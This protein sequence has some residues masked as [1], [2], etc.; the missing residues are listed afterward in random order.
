MLFFLGL[1]ALGFNARAERINI[2]GLAIPKLII[3]EVRVSGASSLYVEL[4][5]M[6]DTAINLEPFKLHQ[7][8]YNTRC[9]EYSDSAISFNR[10]NEAVNSQIGKIYLKGVLQPGESILI[11]NVYDANNERGTGIPIHNTAIAQKGDQFAHI[12]ESLNEN[13][14]IDKPEWQCFGRDSVSSGLHEFLRGGET[15]GYLI[16]WT[17]ETDSAT[18]DS[19]YIDN[20]NH[21]WYPE[22]QAAI[23]AN[24]SSKGE[25]IFPIAGVV[26]AIT[27]SVLVR[28]ANVTEGNL[29]WDQS[30][31]TDANTSE[32][33]VIPQNAS[34]DLAFT[35]VG[36]HGVYDLDYSVKDPS[37]IIINGGN[38]S[39]PWQMAREDSLS[40][41]FNLGDGMSWG[42]D[43]VGSF[44]DSAS[45][46]ARTGDMFSLYAVGNE[47]NK[48]EFTLQVREAEADVALVFP[49][50]QLVE[51]IEIIDDGS[52]SATAVDTIITIG[53]S[54]GFVYDVVQGPET[55]SII[56]VPFATR[57][58][59]LFKYLVKPEK[60][61]WEFIFVDGN[62]RVDLQFGDKLKVT[63]ED[64][65]TVKEYFV[66]VSD[67]VPGE[68]ALLSTV[69]WPDVDKTLYPRWN[70]GDTLPEF[71][72]LKT[73]Y[74]VELHFE[75]TQIPA[76]QFITEDLKSRI[77]VNNAVNVDGSLE[78]R[79]TSVTVY[80]E[81]DTTVLT[82]N[83]I[84]QKQGVPVQP[85]VLE[86]FISE[87]VHGV[88]TQGWAVEIY[89]PGTEDLNLS[90]YAFVSGSQSQTWQE[91]VETLVGTG[92]AFSVGAGN[93]SYNTHYFPSK[94]WTADYSLEAW[95]ALP[96]EENP[97]LGKGFL[98]DDNQTDPWV[99]GGDVWIMGI[100]MNTND[101]QTK[102]REESDFLFRGTGES[103]P[104]WDS[105]VL[106]HRETVIWDA[107]RH[108][109]WLLKV[110]NDS[111]LDGTKDVRDASAYELIDRWEIIGDSVAGRDGITGNNW[112]FVRKSTVVKG[113]LE[114][115][116][117][118][119]ETA[120]SSE[121]IVHRGTDLDWTNEDHVANLGIHTINPITNYLST[122]TS[123]FFLVTPGYTGDNL[124][125]TGSITDYTPTTIS[126]LL[127]K[128]DASQTF[129]YMRGETELTA[130]QSLADGDVLVVSAGDGKSITNYTLVNSPLDGNTSLMAKAGSGLTV[131]DDK[132][133]G[134]TVGMT[135]KEALENLEVAEKSVLNVL[136]ATGALQPLNVYTLDSM[137]NDVLVSEKFSLQVVAENNDNATYY[138]D[139]GLAS[140]EAV[141]LSN[142]LQI[143]QDKKWIMDLP[144]GS[145]ASSILSMVFANEGATYRIL[146]KAGFERTM[147]FIYIDDVI[148]VTA[149]DGVTKV[150]YTFSED[151]TISVHPKAESPTNVVI[152]PNP[153]K[154][155][156]NIKGFELAS[157][158]VI[159]ISGTKMI[160]QTASYS[161]RIDVSSLPS[162][163][164]VIRMTDEEGRIAIDKFLKK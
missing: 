35:T 40:R 59:S 10:A 11:A 161:N 44:E 104:A 157:F 118:F 113:S 135:L 123:V 48:M 72:P 143:D 66:S 49:R 117:G 101:Y 137:V 108:N 2:P 28:K 133:T 131:A 45:F 162:G 142:F 25:W 82:Y 71:T 146:D 62:E 115:M 51:T 141:L 99:E 57:T 160:Y 155:V 61:S 79:T 78:Q 31:G 140:N 152:F 102:I 50:R 52:G 37:N 6:G 122:V 34:Q 17:F 83:F 124:T 116:G 158:E 114:R 58:D 15:I 64:G 130:D 53:W 145:T 9:T 22:D 90:Q 16:H 24:V 67:Y 68:N 43:L 126:E 138:F 41:Y 27:T 120:E 128:A 91:A 30:R 97:Y 156:L 103:T 4:T 132:V 18:L 148:E 151:M 20:F 105:L 63:S 144:L 21:F 164:Y 46:L 42:Y 73:S 112:S 7:V 38:I 111:I 14:W 85:N 107:P 26:D 149:P 159:S 39:V 98:R 110:L 60:A 147:G 8:F 36:L 23:G 88:T 125:I 19:T 121:W 136:D 89:N 119:N 80:A 86:P 54:V 65:T 100:G 74:N 106:L 95:D 87:W 76:F 69:L 139:F 77:E 55:D 92:N 154:S 150:V 93:K 127:D 56:N 70:A 5:N 3:S 33:L 75:A 163:I 84:F 96:T 109:N 29:D 1:L 134:V 47:V 129:A 81:S 32:W 94:R 153:V 13:G 12:D